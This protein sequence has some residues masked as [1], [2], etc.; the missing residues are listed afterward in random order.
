M[1]V[2]VCVC[3]RMCVL[4]DEYTTSTITLCYQFCHERSDIFYTIFETRF[5]YKEAALSTQACCHCFKFG[6]FVQINMSL[7]NFSNS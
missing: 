2:C 1:C 7:H 6:V 3:V 5:L 4:L